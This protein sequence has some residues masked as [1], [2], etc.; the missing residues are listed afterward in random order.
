MQN[1]QIVGT[2]LVLLQ[3]VLFAAN[4]ARRAETMSASVVDTA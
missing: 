4:G 2:F 3:I 1:L